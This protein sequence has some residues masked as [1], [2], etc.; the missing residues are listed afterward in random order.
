MDRLRRNADRHRGNTDRAGPNPDRGQGNPDRFGRSADRRRRVADRVGPSADR[1]RGYADRLR[2]PAPGSGAHG[3]TAITLRLAAQT[4]SPAS[5]STP[6]KV[7][8]L[9]F[10]M[11]S[12]CSGTFPAD[13]KPPRPPST[14]PFPAGAPLPAAVHCRILREHER[15]MCLQRALR[16]VVRPAARGAT[17]PWRKF[18]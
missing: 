7:A 18:S 4:S 1:T 11:L 5:A 6:L 13:L 14:L 17:R 9:A 16:R 12:Q 8:A 15:L 3:N 10:S 2:R